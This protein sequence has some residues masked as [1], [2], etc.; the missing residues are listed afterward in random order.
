MELS[1]GALW[2]LF[3]LFAFLFSLS[4][5]LLLPPSPSGKARS[6]PP[7]CPCEFVFLERAKKS[8]FVCGRKRY[9]VIILVPS[10]NTNFY[11]VHV[12]LY[13]EN[14]NNNKMTS[15]FSGSSWHNNS[16]L[17]LTRIKLR[18][19]SSRRRG[20]IFLARTFPASFIFFSAR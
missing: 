8:V 9:V 16:N 3:S 4:S 1:V 18:Q 19:E 12:L 5:F 15:S 6:V 10:N 17:S 2:R 13:N 14:N 11:H 7:K 20:D